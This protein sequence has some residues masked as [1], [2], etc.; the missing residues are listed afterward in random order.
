LSSPLTAHAPRRRPA[1]SLSQPRDRTRTDQER[2]RPGRIAYQSRAD[3]V[4]DSTFCSFT[5]PA[6]PKNHR[7]VVEHVSGALGFPAGN[8]RGK[9]VI[10]EG[11]A[12][13][14]FSSFIA[15]PSFLGEIVFDQTVL[16][17][18]DAGSAPFLGALADINLRSGSSATISG[19][20]LDCATTPCA[21]IAP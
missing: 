8:G 11:R 12:N 16:Q 1:T 19:Y 20:L 7:L 5:F 21:A 3:C 2:R 14:A 6:A 13:A 4:L 15:P 10:F 9:R 18:F 17:Y